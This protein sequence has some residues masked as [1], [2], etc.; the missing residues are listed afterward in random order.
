MKRNTVVLWTGVVLYLM[1]WLLP[2]A[3]GGTTLA[4]GGVPGWEAFRLALSPFWPYQGS[5]GGRGVL[6]LLGAVSALTNVW[7]IWATVVL[8]ARRERFRRVALWGL[9]LSVPL[10]A[11]WFVFIDDRAGL[12]AGYYAWLGAF[13]VL[14]VAAYSLAGEP[15]RRGRSAAVAS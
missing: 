1:A 9:A 4:Q 14:A 11:I 3:D 10:N 2:V 8:A 15:A 12:R 5:G 13:V 6:D 7:L